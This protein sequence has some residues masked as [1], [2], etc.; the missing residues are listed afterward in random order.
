MITL[1]KSLFVLCSVLVFLYVGM[2]ASASTPE[3][4]PYPGSKHLCGEHV[5]GMPSDGK[6]GPHIVWEAYY[7]KVDT[8]KVADFYKKHL[9]IEKYRFEQ[10]SHEW[11][12]SD[13]DSHSSVLSIQQSSEGGPWT[14]CESTIPQ[15]GTIIMI[16]S[17]TKPDS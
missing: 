12:F 8:N 5:T 4:K 14:S 7:S 3:I 11:S 1:R 2:P 10:G 13:A 9:G 17:M 6:A 16:S 15:Q